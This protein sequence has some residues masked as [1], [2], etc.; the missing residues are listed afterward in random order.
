MISLLGNIIGSIVNGTRFMILSASAFYASLFGGLTLLLIVICLA[1]FLIRLVIWLFF[2][3]TLNPM[4]PVF[5][6][7]R[8]AEIMENA[9]MTDAVVYKPHRDADMRL[10]ASVTNPLPYPVYL[11]ISCIVSDVVREG[12]KVVWFNTE[13][14][15]AHVTD[16]SISI[17]PGDGS[18]FT[19]GIKSSDC[20]L[21]EATIAVPWWRPKPQ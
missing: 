18:G 13:R 15:G 20:T 8:T 17:E 2:L 5:E 21:E 11:G 4:F 19:F 3:V 1:Q 12:N 6:G 9:R 10:H 14:I 16:A 7:Q